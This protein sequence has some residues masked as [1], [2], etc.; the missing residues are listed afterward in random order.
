[1]QVKWRILAILTFLAVLVTV[2]F[3]AFQEQRHEPAVIIDNRHSS[4]HRHRARRSLATTPNPVEVLPTEQA[5]VTAQQTTQYQQATSTMPAAE[6]EFIYA[7]QQ[8]QTASRSA[9]N[10]MAKGGTR[11]QRRQAICSI[12]PSA[13]VSDW[14]G[15]IAQL[16]SNGDGKGVLQISLG[17]N[18]RV[19]T[20]N[21]DFSDIDHNTL[22]DPSTPLFETLMRMSVGTRVVFSG[23]FF[24]SKVD[25]VEEQSMTLDGSMTSPEFVFRFATVTSVAQ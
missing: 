12:L 24:P 25:C 10:E 9:P 1:M 13:T 19:E 21:N 14:I 23:S 15:Q 22:I 11:F 6:Q 16:E 7:V 3:Y 17:E 20:S 8:G 4:P 5:N 18:I 2:G